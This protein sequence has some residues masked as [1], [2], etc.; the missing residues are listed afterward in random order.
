MM[1]K[2]TVTLIFES[3]QMKDAW[4]GWFVDGG[5]EQLMWLAPGLENTYVNHEQMKDDILTIAN[6]EGSE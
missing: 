5:G 2:N 6:A 3:E 1:D 4:M